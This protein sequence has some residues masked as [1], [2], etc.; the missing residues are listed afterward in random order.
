MCQFFCKSAVCIG[1]TRLLR[2]VVRCAARYDDTGIFCKKRSEKM[3]QCRV[4]NMVDAECCFQAVI[5]VLDA[6][7]KLHRG[8]QQQDGDWR[9]TSLGDSD[10]KGSDALQIDQVEQE[11]MNVFVPCELPYGSS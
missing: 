6:I 8:V 2:W 7:G 1:H 5:G 4:S 10:G 11:E 9:R 3:E